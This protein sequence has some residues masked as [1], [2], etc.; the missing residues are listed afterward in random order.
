VF[1]HF[2]VH[3]KNKIREIVEQSSTSPAA[4][5][6]DYICSP[7]KCHLLFSGVKRTYS[8]LRLKVEAAIFS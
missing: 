2:Q 7:F 8:L 5:K 6:F 4:H 1:L 3:K